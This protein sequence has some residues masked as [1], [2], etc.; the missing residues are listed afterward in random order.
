MPTVI[1]LLLKVS[2]GLMI[3]GVILTPLKIINV[4][5]GD[6]YHGMKASDAGFEGFGEAYF[7]SVD[8]DVIKAWKKHNKMT[9]NLVV[10]VGRIGFVIFDDRKNSSTGGSHQQEILDMHNYCR[11]TIPPGLWFGFKGLGKDLNLLMNMA[12]IEHTY[13]EGEKK[14]ID[15]LDYD[16]SSV[17]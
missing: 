14:S 1:L 7:S 2:G 11:I 8:T 3:E 6:V 15:E 16:W 12:N 9:L 5:G 17:K 4:S 13:L 10:P